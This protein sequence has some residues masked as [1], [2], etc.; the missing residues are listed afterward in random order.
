MTSTEH[1]NSTYLGFDYG[2]KNIG[3]AVGQRITGT[4]TALETI[5]FT[6][7][8]A[9]WLA[10]DRLT[11]TWQP[12]AFVVGLPYHPDGEINHIVRPIL[13]FCIELERRFQ[14][15]VYT[16]DETLS[17]RESKEIFYALRENPRHSKRTTQFLDVK[18][19]MAA[20]LILQ[21]W[22]THTPER[23]ANVA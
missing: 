14:K 10:V 1:A 6:S 2:E 11:E 16:M 20:K 23:N 5:R 18:D 12:A 15:P 4:A 22:L 17:T 19:Q 3:V 9:L 13:A 21:T 7:E 8:Y